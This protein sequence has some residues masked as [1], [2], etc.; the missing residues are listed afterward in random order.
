MEKSYN[1]LEPSK[2]KSL[3][4]SHTLYVEKPK[5]SEENV[6]L[7]IAEQKSLED[8]NSPI[9]QSKGVLNK[10]YKILFDIKEDYLSNTTK[11][12]DYKEDSTFEEHEEDMRH[13]H[14]I[15][16]TNKQLLVLP[17]SIPKNVLKVD[18]YKL[19]DIDFNALG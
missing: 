18:P 2:N 15:F 8:V 14:S 6:L 1:S 4:K 11:T 13:F 16:P 10:E 3:K 7:D 12:E 9:K 5:E 17:P 19:E